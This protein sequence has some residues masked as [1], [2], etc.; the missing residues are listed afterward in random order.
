M[1]K[2]LIAVAV[3]GLIACTSRA[4]TQDSIGV[5]DNVGDISHGTFTFGHPANDQP[6]TNQL[7]VYCDKQQAELIT[8][9]TAV[10]VQQSSAF[11]TLP[12]QQTSSYPFSF[13]LSSVPFTQ[14]LTLTGRDA[15]GNPTSRTVTLTINSG[16]WTS[17]PVSGNR[18]K[19][20]GSSEI[21]ITNVQQ[22]AL[23]YPCG[24]EHWDCLKPRHS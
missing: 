10:G 15:N 24:H 1:R 11:F 6:G 17:T 14:T 19:A 3:L 21:V 8:D 20:T 12:C 9:V 13:A 7:I 16:S 18:A 23:L 22:A 4:Q 2:S 5:T